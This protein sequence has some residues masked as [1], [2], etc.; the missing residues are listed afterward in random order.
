M[1]CLV[2]FDR[3]L[4]KYCNFRMQLIR[5]LLTQIGVIISRFYRELEGMIL[6]I[7]LKL[8]MDY[9]NLARVRFLNSYKPTIYMKF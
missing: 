9:Q 3:R 4:M 7:N 1:S 2:Q 5:S 6:L 8:R